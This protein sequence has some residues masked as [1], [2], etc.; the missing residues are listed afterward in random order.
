MSAV[1]VPG[2][3]R[4]DLTHLHNNSVGSPLLDFLQIA[5][6]SIL[7]IV[8]I[9]RER[10]RSWL[11]GGRAGDSAL[12]A[13]AWSWTPSRSQLCSLQ[14]AYGKLAAFPWKRAP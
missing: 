14:K 2:L 13:G 10:L 3:G 12:V 9:N 6:D 8:G 11:L 7:Q 4:C 1:L 5:I